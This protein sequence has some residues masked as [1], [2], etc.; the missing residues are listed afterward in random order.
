MWKKFQ[1]GDD[2]NSRLGGKMFPVNGVKEIENTIYIMLS[3][4]GT[5]F[6]KAI[7][8]YTRKELNHTSIAFDEQLNEMYSFGRKNKHN[9]FIGGF[10]REDATSELFN[11]ATCAIYKCQ[12]SS[13]E[14]K[15]MR[16]KI[17]LMEQQKELY[18]YNLLGLF[19]LAMNMKIER[20]HAFFCSQF[21]ATIMNESKSTKLNVPP[22]LVQPHHFEQLPML[23]LLYKGQLQTYIFSK[24][25]SEEPIQVSAWEKYAFQMQ[26]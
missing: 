7:G 24:R 3:N 15:Q 22:Y 13:H 14:Y 17:R 10:I 8:M 23:K 2:L 11:R 25:G 19:G 9:P 26:P 6:S 1:I 20:E 21:V 4:T 12:V 5:L 18:K 16:N